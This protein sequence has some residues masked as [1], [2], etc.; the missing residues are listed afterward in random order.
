[1]IWNDLPE[2]LHE[3]VAGF[4]PDADLATASLASSAIHRVFSK[5][6]RVRLET[7]E[8]EIF[9]DLRALHDAIAAADAKTVELRSSRVLTDDDYDPDADGVEYHL[10]DED[11][12]AIYEEFSDRVFENMDTEVEWATDA[13]YLNNPGHR[14]EFRDLTLSGLLRGTHVTIS[15]QSSLRGVGRGYAF[16]GEEPDDGSAWANTIDGICPKSSYEE[17]FKRAYAKFELL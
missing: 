6:L 17:A 1:M 8:A 2:E 14:F 12:D 15:V 10:T 3:T 4:L 9:D 5:V 7:A 13:G 16:V 11:Y